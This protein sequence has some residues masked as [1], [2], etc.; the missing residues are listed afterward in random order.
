MLRAPLLLLLLGTASAQEVTP[1][2]K[3]CSQERS[4]RAREVLDVY[5]YP[6]LP[7]MGKGNLSA[8]CALQ[9]SRDMYR[10]Y[11][12]H[13]KEVRRN[14]WKCLFCDKIF[15]TE[16]FL[17]KHYENRHLSE[18][19]TD[20][21]VCLA[22]Y[23]DVLHCDAG[24]MLVAKHEQLKACKQ[25]DM[26]KRRHRCE[27]VGHRC[28]PPEDG[29]NMAHLHDFFMHQFCDAHT[30]SADRQ[31]F[32]HGMAEKSHG[33]LYLILGLITAGIAILYLCIYCIERDKP[34]AGGMQR[35]RQPKA[36]GM[37][38]ML[39]PWRGKKKKVY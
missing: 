36:K 7:Q 4:R 18:I 15:R 38:A 31:M 30:C 23:C 19:P 10:V 26:A 29:A 28:F 32:P 27:A 24:S 22:D 9:P 33:F 17:D 2:V 1:M 16:H 34:R 11:E 35:L 5:F 21:E 6:F 39:M 14:Q 12:Q 3:K 20:A 8:D 13:K 25:T 37:L